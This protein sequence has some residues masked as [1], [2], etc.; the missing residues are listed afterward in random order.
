[1]PR[2]DHPIL[3]D[4][5]T[6]REAVVLF[7]PVPVLFADINLGE[8]VGIHGKTLDRRRSTLE[9]RTNDDPD[10]EHRLIV[11]GRSRDRNLT[12]W[13]SRKT[14]VLVSHGFGGLTAVSLMRKI[15]PPVRGFS[16]RLIFW[17]FT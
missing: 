9:R 5:I 4:R 6:R 3:C 7:F 10:L 8:S 2:R 11:A 13:W 16:F 15:S 1:M 17:V 14:R 12:A